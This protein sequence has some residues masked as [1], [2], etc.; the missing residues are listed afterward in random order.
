[1]GIW[2]G[3]VAAAAAVTLAGVC[4]LVAFGLYRK[5]KRKDTSLESENSKTTIDDDTESPELTTF[6]VDTDSL[7]K[8]SRVGEKKFLVQVFNLIQVIFTVIG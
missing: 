6:K 1:M 7:N 8:C 3:P 2:V 4:A 5:K